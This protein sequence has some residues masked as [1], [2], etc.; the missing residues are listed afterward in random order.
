MV[1]AAVGTVFAA[2]YLLWMFQRTAMG[3]PKPEFAHAHI[4][5]VHVPE[6]IAWAPM[7]VLIVVLGVYPHALFQ[8][9]D[10]AVH[11]ATAQIAPAPVTIA[12]PA[13]GP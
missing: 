1:I 8:T 12:T 2:G 9:T 5:D 4:H 3:V 10:G 6:W 7:L 13:P 11:Q